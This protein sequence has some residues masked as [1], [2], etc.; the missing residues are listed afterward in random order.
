MILF[1][2]KKNEIFVCGLFQFNS[3]LKSENEIQYD[4]NSFHCRH[5]II[6]GLCGFSF[7]FIGLVLFGISIDMNIHTVRTLVV[8]GSRL[9][10]PNLNLVS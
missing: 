6:F 9:D 8:I 7:F 3:V 5:P 2:R 1:K 10:D 4:L